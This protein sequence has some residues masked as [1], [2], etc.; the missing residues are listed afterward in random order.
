MA[1][2]AEQSG[3]LQVW[4]LSKSFGGPPVLRGVDWQLMPGEVHALVGENG[5]GKST[6]LK[7][8][9]GVHQ[10]DS[11]DIAIDGA[12]V[13]I[14]SPAVAQSL[15]IAQ[16]FQEPTLFPDLSVAENIFAGRY[17]VAAPLP[18]IR[19]R[20]MR[21][22]A[23]ALLQSIG[24][25]IAPDRRVG[26]LSVAEQQLV[27]IAAALSHEARFVLMD[28]PTASLTPREVERLFGVIRGLKGTGRWCRLC[29]SP[30]RRGVCDL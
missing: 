24:A 6:L 7:L 26:T 28:E 12:P 5:A 4:G 27:E 1:Q 25:R 16:I 18:F 29:E 17:P 2:A 30:V 23:E 14:E 20:A 22:E 19:W 9:T 8:L 15:G 21:E 3:V 11:G 10:P 13:F